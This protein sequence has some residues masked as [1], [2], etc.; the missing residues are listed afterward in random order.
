MSAAPHTTS[1]SPS[2]T[3]DDQDHW[4]IKP[5]GWR[6][7]FTDRLLW[8]AVGLSFAAH[9]VLLA[10]QYGIRIPQ[11]GDTSLIVSFRAANQPMIR[12]A[13]SPAVTDKTERR[14]KETKTRVIQPVPATSA[15]AP[16]IAPVT[17]VKMPSSALSTPAG[18]AIPAGASGNRRVTLTPGMKDYRYSQYLED[19]RRKVERIGAMNYP[20]EARGKF[21]G[22]LVLSVALRPDGS[23]DRILVTRSSGNPVL[24]EAAKR[25]VTFAAPFAP[26]PPDIRQE[27]DYLDITRTWTFTRGS[28]LETR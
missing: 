6:L 21:F 16:R 15:S 9:L 1:P 3:R 12:N 17:G 8:L 7:I 27:T 10:P 24:D 18:N 2:Q 4:Q 20:E 26:F 5:L 13:P 11:R 25:I 14:H 22:S 28:T 23:V 19:W